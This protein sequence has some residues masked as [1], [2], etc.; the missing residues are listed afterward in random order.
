M[1]G[2]GIGQ[3]SYFGSVARGRSPKG[4]NSGTKG[5]RSGVGFLEMGQ[6]VPS[7][8]VGTRAEPRSL[9]IKFS[10]IPEAPVGLFGKLWERGSGVTATR[11]P[12]AM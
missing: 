10:R 6:P 9:N 2:G 3:T 8:V 7:P 4:R 5:P 11:L 12:H 1:L